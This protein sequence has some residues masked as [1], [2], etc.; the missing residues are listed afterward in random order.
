MLVG[1]DVG[2]GDD[3][4]AVRH[5]HGPVRIPGQVLDRLDLPGRLLQVLEHLALRVDRIHRAVQQRGLERTE[6]EVV[7]VIAAQPQLRRVVHPHLQHLGLVVPVIR[8]RELDHLD[9]VHRHA[10]DPQHELD[11]GVL[12][13]TPPVVLDRVQA[14]G[15]TDL[16]P[17]QVGHRV[18]VVA[19]AHQHAA[20]LVHLRRTQQPRAADIRVDVDRRVQP[21]E[22]DQV[23]QV[24]DVVRI[25]VVL[26]AGPEVRVLDAELLELLTTP[27]QLL[28]H[29]VRRNHRAVREVHLVP[30]QRH[31][32]RNRALR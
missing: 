23:V 25:P 18:D 10:V 29:V 27:P 13:D 20:T 3:G 26:I 22:A 14:L 21:T 31:R 28:V 11:A 1:H 12:L 9:V 6:G 2:A 4:R 17:S 19:G 8:I 7:L 15:E 5:L 16:L 32:G 30:P 24:V